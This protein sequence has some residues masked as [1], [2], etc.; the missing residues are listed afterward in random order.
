MT[1]MMNSAQHQPLQDAQSLADA[2]V[3]S[4]ATNPTAQPGLP[5]FRYNPLKLRRS[6]DGAITVQHEVFHPIADMDAFYAA[7]GYDQNARD[8]GLSGEE[9]VWDRYTRD[10]AKMSPQCLQVQIAVYLHNHS[11]KFNELYGQAYDAMIGKCCLSVLDN[12]D[13]HCAN[14]SMDPRNGRQ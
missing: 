4:A 8:S 9:F 2:H 5:V 14:C 6:T 11:P 7:M 1:M 12:G 10:K 13:K 3:V